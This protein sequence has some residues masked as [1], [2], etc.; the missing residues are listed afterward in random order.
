M[1]VSARSEMTRVSL[2]LLSVLVI[3]L[4]WET[5]ARSGYQQVTGEVVDVQR[6]FPGRSGD[7]KAFVVH[8]EIAGAESNLVLRRGILDLFSS[9]ASLRPGDRVSVLASTTPPHNAVLN[10]LNG[11]YPISLAFTTLTLLFGAVALVI[12]L[13]RR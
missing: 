1:S 11:R 4:V 12:F 8:F 6:V 3:A 7:N 10:T 9:L 2:L 5:Q 13:R